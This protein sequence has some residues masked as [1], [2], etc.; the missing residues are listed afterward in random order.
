[1]SQVTIIEYLKHLMYKYTTI[2]DF[3]LDLDRI[4]LDFTQDKCNPN[5][6]AFYKRLRNKLKKIEVRLEELRVEIRAERIS[7]GE[8]AELESLSD[9]INPNDVELLQ[10]ANIEEK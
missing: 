8:I 7:Y 1:M 9:F 5:Q 10:W 2:E 6:L 4:I 3:K